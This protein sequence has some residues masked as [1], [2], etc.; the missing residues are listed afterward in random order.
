M[1]GGRNKLCI[2]IIQTLPAFNRL[3]TSA[4]NDGMDKLF[5]RSP[6]AHSRSFSCTG[7]S[8]R[9]QMAESLLRKYDGDRFEVHSAG[10]EAKARQLW[11]H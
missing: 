4:A 7:N 9:S 8:V 10:L 2:V 5:W 1:I 3:L 11:D 6:H